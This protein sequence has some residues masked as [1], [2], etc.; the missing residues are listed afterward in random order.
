MQYAMYSE[1][2][3]VEIVIGYYFGAMKCEGHETSDTHYVDTTVTPHKMR[4]RQPLTVTTETAAL[5]ATLSGIPIGS[6]IWTDGGDI[7]THDDEP[8]TIEFDLPGTYT[9]EIMPPVQYLDESM[10]VTVGDP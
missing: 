10:E 9:I 4:E 3:R 1:G 5:S 8:L 7:T 6:N 2:G